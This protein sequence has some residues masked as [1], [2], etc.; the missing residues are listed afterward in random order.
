MNFMVTMWG[1]S[2]IRY[3]GTTDIMRTSVVNLELIS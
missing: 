1:E 3:A 2:G